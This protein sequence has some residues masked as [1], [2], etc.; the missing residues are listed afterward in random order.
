M[1]NWRL[2]EWQLAASCLARCKA[3]I[4]K[5]LRGELP[6]WRRQKR[7]GDLTETCFILLLVSNY[8]LEYLD[9]AALNAKC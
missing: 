7:T 6:K 8:S 9:A 3:A 4:S 1:H 2:F 5:E